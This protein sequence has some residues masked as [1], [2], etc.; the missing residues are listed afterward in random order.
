[1]QTTDV[2]TL[3]TQ[4]IAECGGQWRM[5]RMVSLFN[6]GRAMLEQRALSRTPS[7]EGDR[8][9]VEVARLMYRKDPFV[10]RFLAERVRDDC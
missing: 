10:Q 3:Y 8:L 9:K 4:K 7:L 1:M 2:E 6:S 5:A